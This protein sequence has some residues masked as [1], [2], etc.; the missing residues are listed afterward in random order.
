MRAAEEQ[1]SDITSRYDR[2][3]IKRR[4]ELPCVLQPVVPPYKLKNEE[5]EETIIA[6]A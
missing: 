3:E 1:L 2:D 6:V 5:T 4:T